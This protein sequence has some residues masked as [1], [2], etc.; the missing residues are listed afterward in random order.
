MSKAIVK[1]LAIKDGGRIPIPSGTR[2]SPLIE[3]E[4]MS[5]T[6]AW[7]SDFIC[8]ET[9]D[10][11]MVVEIGFLVEKAPEYLLTLGAKFKLYEG[12]KLV[13]TGVVIN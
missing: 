2:Y 13:A 5:K 7:S 12:I 11:E 8:T 10:G 6:E 9:V 4:G 3:I 1:W